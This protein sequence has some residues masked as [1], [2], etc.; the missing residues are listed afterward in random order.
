MGMRIFPTSCNTA[1]RPS[2][3]R[4]SRATPAAA[5]RTGGTDRDVQ[6]VIIKGVVHGAG[7][8]QVQQEISLINCEHRHQILHQI[9]R[10]GG[11]LDGRVLHGGHRGPGP[12]ARGAGMVFRRHEDPCDRAAPARYA[13][14]LGG[15]TGFL[16]AGD[17]CSPGSDFRHLIQVPQDVGIGQGR[18]D[19]DGFQAQATYNLALALVL[20]QERA[21]QERVRHPAQA[22]RPEQAGSQPIHGNAIRSTGDPRLKGM[23]ILARKPLGTGADRLLG[24]QGDQSLSA[25]RMRFLPACLAA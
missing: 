13:A 21:A 14:V 17:L 7:V 24:V 3:T 18:I 12:G 1:P 15:G 19:V 25:G 22:Q 8:H 23:K 5:R 16:V 10:L 9:L 2:N 6:R 4:S 11:R 20:E